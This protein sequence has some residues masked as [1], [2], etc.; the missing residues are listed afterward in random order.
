MG[1]QNSILIEDRS[2]KSEELDL[3]AR[4][5]QA[6]KGKLLKI[7]K[8]EEEEYAET[9]M[10]HIDEILVDK[11]LNC[12]LKKFRE[13]NKIAGTEVKMPEVVKGA[14]VD[15]SLQNL[16][17]LTSTQGRMNDYA[18]AVKELKGNLPFEGKFA[19]DEQNNV[20]EGGIL[21]DIQEVCEA[22]TFLA[23]EATSIVMFKTVAAI[24]IEDNSG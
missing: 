6:G 18:T 19:G 11:W 20:A 15:T 21:R 5:N 23:K 14:G 16:N 3:I 13:E 22:A 12:L 7:V 10:Q 17:M 1:N 9:N 24:K 4:S 8:E 2:P